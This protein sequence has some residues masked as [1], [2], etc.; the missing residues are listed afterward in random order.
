[1]AVPV[2]DGVTEFGVLP[3][4]LVAP[5]VVAAGAVLAAGALLVP[6]GVVLVAGAVAAAP[7]VLADGFGDGLAGAALPTDPPPKVVPW[8]ALPSTTAD[9]GLPAAP[10]IRVTT[11]AQQMNAAAMT[12]AGPAHRGH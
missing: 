8:P 10:S 3:A 11:T 9:S 6:L 1:M 4:G 5:G 7:V 12:A 2:A